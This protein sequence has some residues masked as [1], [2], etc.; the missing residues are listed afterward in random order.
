VLAFWPAVHISS[1]RLLTVANQLVI[2]DAD[3]LPYHLE[4]H[5]MQSALGGLSITDLTEQAKSFG[6]AVHF[7]E[8]KAAR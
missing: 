8:R 5:F 7:V 2:E 6:A 4:R 1:L 3:W